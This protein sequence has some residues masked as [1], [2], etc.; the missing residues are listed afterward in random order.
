MNPPPAL[1]LSVAL[2][3]EDAK[4]L[5]DFVTATVLAQQRPN[6]TP[7]LRFVEKPLPALNKAGVYQP[8]RTARTLQQLW[9]YGDGREE[10][11]DVPLE[12]L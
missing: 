5:S 12:K 1:V 7:R 11:Q 2:S 9:A 6:A 3:A 8:G 10:W 4:A